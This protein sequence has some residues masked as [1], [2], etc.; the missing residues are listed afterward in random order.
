MIGTQT[1]PSPTPRSR[2]WYRSPAVVFLVAVAAVLV[3]SV[4]FVIFAGGGSDVTDTAA[5]TAPAPE[6]TTTVPVT[7]LPTTVPETTVPSEAPVTERPLA[8]EGWQIVTPSLDL[9]AAS[10]A[11]FVSVVATDSGFLA[12][13][14]AGDGIWTSP[15]G[16][17][18]TEVGDPG[19]PVGLGVGVDFYDLAANGDRIAAVIHNG[20]DAVTGIATSTDAE[21]WTFTALSESSGGDSDPTYPLSIAAYGTDGFIVSGNAIWLSA[22]GEEYELV[23]EGIARDV[24]QIAREFWVSASDGQTVVLG[25]SFAEFLVTQDGETWELI[26][27]L[28]GVDGEGQACSTSLEDLAYGSG[29]FVAVGSCGVY[30]TA[31]TSPDGSVWSQIPYDDTAFGVPAWPHS[32]AVSERGYVVGGHSGPDGEVRVPT[33]WT[34]PDGIH[35][36]RVVL[37]VSV[38]E[39]G[40]VLGVAIYDNT[41]AAVGWVDAEATIWQ[42]VLAG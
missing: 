20:W 25:T 29:G 7:T 36:T 17:E 35:W 33:V 19:D 34:S 15:D 40:G 37:E 3:V 12:I 41:L 27:Q 28:V 23:H 18:W 11:A 42:A 13:G 10:A 26:P 14:G 21:N 1:R 24:D 38:V 32:I 30:G 22:D 5:P 16:V 9:G 4:P 6:V 2:P 39:D 8:L 31:W